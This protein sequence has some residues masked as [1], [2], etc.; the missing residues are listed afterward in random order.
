MVA[1]GIRKIACIAA[2]AADKSDMRVVDI[3]RGNRLHGIIRFHSMDIG[4]SVDSVSGSHL[5]REPM[6]NKDSAVERGH[7]IVRIRVIDCMRAAADAGVTLENVIVIQHVGLDHILI[8]AGEGGEHR[9]PDIAIAAA[10][11]I[12]PESAA[13]QVIVYFLAKLIRIGFA[14]V[15]KL[16]VE[17]C[18][19]AKLI[20]DVALIILNI[21]FGVLNIIG[22]ALDL[23]F[24]C[25]DGDLLGGRAILDHI[26]SIL[27]DKGSRGGPEIFARCCVIF[28]TDLVDQLKQRVFIGLKLLFT[29][30]QP[31]QEHGDGA[32]HT[33]PDRIAGADRLVNIHDGSA[34]IGH[35]IDLAVL[36][37]DIVFEPGHAGKVI[38]NGERNRYE[39]K[40]V[41]I[42]ITIVAIIKM[43]R[44]RSGGNHAHPDGLENEQIIAADGTIL[45]TGEPPLHGAFKRFR[46]DSFVDF[47]N[48]NTPFFK[49]RT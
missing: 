16:C 37:G 25:V 44:F 40:E 2:Q 7:L 14:K 48:G 6:I 49:R 46:E 28:L 4:I 21:P 9:V 42:R 22:Q 30:E 24:L 45:V 3:V 33:K 29:L 31:G 23:G 5:D 10:D 47:Q 15:G 39:V 19:T 35:D 18:D 13:A 27:G 17:F 12:D 34:F 43:K 11:E 26:V 32:D 38:G 41:R 20:G 1:L 36:R 8:V